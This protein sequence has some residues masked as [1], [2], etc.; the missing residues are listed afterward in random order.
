MLEPICQI[1]P[2]EIKDIISKWGQPS[3]RCKQLL[4]WIYD[5]NILDFAQIS[6]LPKD[7]I[8]RL[9]STFSACSLSVADRKISDDKTAVKYLFRLHDDKLIEGVAIE[10]NKRFTLCVSSQ[11]GC[12]F[13]CVFC[14][15]A[16]SGLLRNLTVAEIIDQI[17]IMSVDKKMTNLVFM[18]SGEP[19]QDFHVFSRSYETITAPWGFA[20]GQRKITVSTAGYIPGIKK[21]IDSKMRP[22]LALSLHS[23]LN[24][25]RNSLMPINKKYPLE[26]LLDTCLSYAK[27]S[28]RKITMEYIIIPGF[29]NYAED[30]KA[31]ARLLKNYPAKIN[32][33]PLNPID[34]F[35]YRSPTKHEVHTFYRQLR[36]T[37]LDVTVRWSKG[38]SISAAC[39]QLRSQRG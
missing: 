23:A 2:A 18:G 14:A 4:K 36:D 20:L 34:E 39:G 10:K 21:L 30:I 3:Y 9:N 37:G 11:A 13:S 5:K 32:L 22:K 35:P 24:E 27:I 25:K 12:S 1:T 29:N 7:L 17:R 31:L 15:S 8:S 19:L 33:I 6:N 38:D 28:G 26:K 16:K